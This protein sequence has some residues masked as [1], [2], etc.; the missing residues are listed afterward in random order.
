[1]TLAYYLEN[2]HQPNQYKHDIANQ[3]FSQNWPNTLIYF[4]QSAEISIYAQ[5]S[6]EGLRMRDYKYL[7]ISVMICT[8][9][10]NRQTHITHRQI[11]IQLIQLLTGYTIRSASWAKNSNQNT[12]CLRWL[13]HGKCVGGSVMLTWWMFRWHWDIWQGFQ[14]VKPVTL[15]VKIHFIF[16]RFLT[17][18]ILVK[19]PTNY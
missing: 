18:K 11:D 4:Q 9:L 12:V 5:S 19:I 7:S 13:Y 15:P 16:S 1:M 10:V 14:P 2:R 8:T 6:S 17:V 3:Q